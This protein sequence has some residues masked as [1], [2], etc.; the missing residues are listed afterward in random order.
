MMPS[1]YA[2]PV[3]R[4]DAAPEADTLVVVN[5]LPER[6]QVSHECAAPAVS[7]G[8]ALLL[9]LLFAVAL[10]LVAAG[11]VAAAEGVFTIEKIEKPPS[12]ADLQ[13]EARRAR[14][15]MKRLQGR[16][17]DLSARYDA[18]RARLDELN[19]DLTRTRLELTSAETALEAQRALVAQRLAAIYKTGEP[20]MLDVIAGFSGFAELQSGLSVLRRIAQSDQ[21]EEFKLEQMTKSAKDLAAALDEQRAEALEVESEIDDQRADV[22]A[23][24]D[25]RR[26]LLEGLTERLEQ[27]LAA[28]LPASLMK[29]PP[30]GHT[31]VTWAKA[32]L[33]ALQMPQTT[34]NMAAIFAWEMAEGGHW[35]NSAHY[36]PLNTTWRMP[37][38]TSMN[39]V[40]VKAYLSWAQGFAATVNTFHNGLYEGI[41]AALRAGNDSQAVADAVAASP[42]GTN[43]FDVGSLVD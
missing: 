23:T 13:R 20:T 14:A 21:A 1:S 41:L 16:L 3:T 11:P 35:Y 30:G 34:D 36:N 5:A 39:S 6:R 8:V 38:A 37:G 32:L 10:A 26:L 15:E 42:W 4:K 33:A 9:A 12:I 40:G 24:L 18:A 2:M 19:R 27:A 22:A 28:G 7:L 29:A 25:E 17:Q 31:P 43:S